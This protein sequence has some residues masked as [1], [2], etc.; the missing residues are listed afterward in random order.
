MDTMTGRVTGIRPL[1]ADFKAPFEHVVMDGLME[2]LRTAWDV[3]D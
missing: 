1:E 3:G 2:R